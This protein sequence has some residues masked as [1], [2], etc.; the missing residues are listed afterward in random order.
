MMARRE[1]TNGGRPRQFRAR[2]RLL[3]EGRGL[4]EERPREQDASRGRLTTV[5]R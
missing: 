5:N 2:E 4:K 3:Y 1:R